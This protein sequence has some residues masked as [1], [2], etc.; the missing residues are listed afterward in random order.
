M[1][2]TYTF[3]DDSWWDNPGC[4]CCPST[5]MEAYNSSDTDCNLGTASS[6]EDCYVQAIVTEVSI[7][8]IPCDDNIWDEPLENLEVIAQGLGIEIKIIS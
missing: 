7:C 4:S 3:Y 6:L 2:K 5:L 1:T 8:N